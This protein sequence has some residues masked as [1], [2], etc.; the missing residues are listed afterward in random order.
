MPANAI[1]RVRQRFI[2]AVGL[3]DPKRQAAH[4]STQRVPV[5]SPLRFFS[6]ISSSKPVFL[7]PGALASDN[8]PLATGLKISITLGGDQFCTRPTLGFELGPVGFEGNRARSPRRS[9]ASCGE[10]ME[11]PLGLLSGSVFFF[12]TPYLCEVEATHFWEF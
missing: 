8:E 6:G 4:C 12:R 2:R 9:I 1:P 11:G 5:P 7:L 3:P 10:A